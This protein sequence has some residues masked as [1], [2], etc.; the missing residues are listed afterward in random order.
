MNYDS[1]KDAKQ[2]LID[3]IVSCIKRKNMELLELL[4]Q[5]LF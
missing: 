3:A 1:P 4:S 2:P 5:L